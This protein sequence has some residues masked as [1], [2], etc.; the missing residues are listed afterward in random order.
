MDDGKIPAPKRQDVA[1]LVDRAK[2]GEIPVEA[3][4]PNVAPRVGR[5]KKPP[6]VDAA[7]QP[8]VRRR[9]KAILTEKSRRTESRSEDIA[10]RKAAAWDA[11]ISEDDW[12]KVYE[13]YRLFGTITELSAHTG[14]SKPIVKHVL[15]NGVRRLGL[16]PIRE[17]AVDYD[18]VAKRTEA[19]V[20]K[21]PDE[22]TEKPA[23]HMQE[24][25]TAVTERAVRETT[26]AQS[27]LITAVK[28]TDIFLGYVNKVMER[29]VDPEGGYALPEKISPALI[30]QLSKIASNL[31]NATDRAIQ[32]SRLTA[33][34]PTQNIALQV[35]SFV[36]ELSPEEL[37]SY[38]TTKE[39]PQRLR[40]GGGN[41]GISG[42]GPTQKKIIDV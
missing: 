14:L 15:D 1:W 13:A 10:L 33:G 31:A 39:L 32:Q 25:K 29:I 37:R 3:L 5:T 22:L 4:H 20:G 41:S 7:V 27:V 8:A 26:A 2:A 23:E 11:K 38:V 9:G 17:L 18:E 6:S 30:E 21:Q 34:E 19:I 35:A 12:A 36:V 42:E 40:A 24:V 28:T 16:R